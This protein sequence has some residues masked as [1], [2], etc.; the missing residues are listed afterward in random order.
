MKTSRTPF[1]VFPRNQFSTMILFFATNRHTKCFVSQQGDERAPW[2]EKGK[3]VCHDSCTSSSAHHAGIS[4]N[5]LSFL[6]C[7]FG[8]SLLQEHQTSTCK[9]L[10]NQARLR[11]RTRVGT[12]RKRGQRRLQRRCQS[13]MGQRR[14]Q[15]RCQSKMTPFH[16]TRVP[17]PP[18]LVLPSVTRRKKGRQNEA[19]TREK[20]KNH[21][22]RPPHLRPLLPGANM[23]RGASMPPPRFHPPHTYTTGPQLVPCKAQLDCWSRTKTD[24]TKLSHAIISHEITPRV[25]Q[26][27]YAQACISFALSR[28]Y[29]TCFLNPR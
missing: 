18:F 15:G 26:P 11:V 24:P 27:Q 20:N 16:T 10:I 29:D 13:R 12:T 14:L 17:L 22:T 23:S 3:T 6:S 25:H 28:N 1:R 7:I 21:P 19:N 9:T 5:E 4:P 2:S 8:I